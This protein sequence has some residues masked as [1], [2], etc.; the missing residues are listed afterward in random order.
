MQGVNEVKSPLPNNKPKI[1]GLAP[2]LQVKGAVERK[3]IVRGCI[4]K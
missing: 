4:K 3:F 1:N 2:I